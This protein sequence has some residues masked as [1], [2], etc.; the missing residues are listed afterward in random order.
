MK[1]FRPV[2]RDELAK[3]E[4][5]GMKAFPPRLPAQPIFYPVLS[6]AYAEQIACDWNSTSDSHAFLGYVVEFDV[7]DAFAARYAPRTVGSAAHREL[8]VPADELAAFNRHI[9][10]DI[11]LVAAYERGQRMDGR[12]RSA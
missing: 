6:F 12:A 4:A 1:L 7:D 10:G 2:G 3:I 5:S 11:R 8:W 9:T